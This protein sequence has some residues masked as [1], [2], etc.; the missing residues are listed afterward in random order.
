MTMLAGH[1]SA[2]LTEHLVKERGC[3]QHTIENYAYSFEL[4]VVS[5]SAKLRVR[6]SRLKVENLTP[7]NIL[8]LLEELEEKRGNSPRTRNVRLAAYKSFGSSQK[9]V[10]VERDL[11]LKSMSS[12]RYLG[13]ST[14]PRYPRGHSCSL[15]V[16]SRQRSNCRGFE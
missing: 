4:L 12:I 3:S 15:G 5:L 10:H 16:W 7:R 2:F 1:L 9:S 11:E 8:A 14:P 6:P 13:V